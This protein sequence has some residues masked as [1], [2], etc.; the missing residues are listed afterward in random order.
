MSKFGNN[1]DLFSFAFISFSLSILI[2]VFF[3]RTNALAAVRDRIRS[4]AYSP[5]NTNKSSKEGEATDK[6]AK[7]EDGL[8]KLSA[9]KAQ[10][11]KSQLN[12]PLVSLN[13]DELEQGWYIVH[14]KVRR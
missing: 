14:R 7:K 11:S 2:N 5:G 6:Q 9:E 4:G 8:E 12:S 13:V 1:N 3:I 10:L